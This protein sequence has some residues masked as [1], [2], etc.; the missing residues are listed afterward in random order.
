[1]LNMCFADLMVCVFG[2]SVALTYNRANT[3]TTLMS[4]SWGCSWLAFINCSTGIACIGTLTAM[5]FMSYKVTTDVFC[6]YQASG[7]KWNTLAGLQIF[8]NFRL[9][10]MNTRSF[11]LWIT[12]IKNFEGGIE[13]W[14]SFSSFIWT[15]HT[16]GGRILN[17]SKTAF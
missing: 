6:F 4:D 13:Y 8:A 10:S 5:S 9:R 12:S 16:V 1:M 7:M 3:G 2:Y 17:R 15:W 14:K 11:Y